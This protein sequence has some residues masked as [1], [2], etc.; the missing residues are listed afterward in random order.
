MKWQQIINSHSS[1]LESRE[2][3][4]DKKKNKKTKRKKNK[5]NRNKSEGKKNDERQKL[6]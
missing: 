4:I 6:K 1:Q 5:K 3:L 2:D